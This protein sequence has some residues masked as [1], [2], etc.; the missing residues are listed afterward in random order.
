MTQRHDSAK[1]SEISAK[2]RSVLGAGTAIATWLVLGWSGPVAAAEPIVIGEGPTKDLTRTGTPTAAPAPADTATP[3]VNVDART[4]AKG[5]ANILLVHDRDF[6]GQDVNAGFAY[7]RANL[8]RLRR[9]GTGGM[10]IKPRDDR[11]FRAGRYVFLSGDGIAPAMIAAVPPVPVAR[12]AQARIAVAVQPMVDDQGRVRLASGAYAV[13]APP[14]VGVAAT[15]PPTAAPAAPV[16]ASVPPV[17]TAAAPTETQ[18]QPE[19]QPK[20][21]ILAEASAV[22]V[23][24][25]RPA[26]P[27]VAVALPPHRTAAG[28]W[29]LERQPTDQP[30]TSTVVAPVPVPK[31][32]SKPGPASA[33]PVAPSIDLAAVVPLPAPAPPVIAAS[34]GV[35][36]ATSAA[37]AQ[38]RYV[39]QREAVKGPAHIA[40]L[41]HGSATGAPNWRW[42]VN[43]QTG[44]HYTETNAHY[45]ARA[46][47]HVLA[48]SAGEFEALKRQAVNHA[49]DLA[50]EDRR[51]ISRVLEADFSPALPQADERL[52]VALA[53]DATQWRATELFARG[54]HGDQGRTVRLVRRHA[55]ILP[56]AKQ[57]IYARF[58]IDARRKI[59]AGSAA[60]LARAIDYPDAL[61]NAYGGFG[62]ALGFAVAPGDYQVALQSI[63]TDLIDVPLL[64][65]LAPGEAAR[66]VI[67]NKGAIGPH[68]I[69]AGWLAHKAPRAGPLVHDATVLRLAVIDIFAEARAMDDRQAAANWVERALVALDVRFDRRR[70]ATLTAAGLIDSFENLG[71][72]DITPEAQAV[73]AV[74]AYFRGDGRVM[75]LAR[76]YRRAA[77]AGE[78]DVSAFLHS[79]RLRDNYAARKIAHLRLMDAERQLLQQ[80]A[81]D[82]ARQLAAL[83][84][85]VA[86][87]QADS[88][89]FVAVNE[90]DTPPWPVRR[91]AQVT[92]AVA[93]DPATPLVDRIEALERDTRLVLASTE[94]DRLVLR[95]R[96]QRVIA[97]LEWLFQSFEQLE[98]AEQR[99]F[100]PRLRALHGALTAALSAAP[101]A[102]STEQQPA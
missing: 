29:V 95:D 5:P 10:L 97:A 51:R 70:M 101:A 76:Q 20:T 69:T 53:T 46:G 36:G 58:A 14:P 59:E 87:Q 86:Q 93:R 66:R 67:S 37:D 1:P 45:A 73:L 38:E 102:G 89:R 84:P 80:F 65:T 82:D 75:S 25:A 41:L 9:V 62:A 21:V 92:Q 57:R 83:P 11:S 34:T 90:L 54:L 17:V 32:A 98:P 8:D 50:S 79:R 78:V 44:D 43:L 18:I 39:S 60:K 64:L 7:Q 74:E 31:S 23:P 24:V 47:V 94:S 55:L 35:E 56:D 72:F 42:L 26:I 88:A 49:R 85:S 100:A 99:A 91:P 4:A 3:V 71:R 77:P 40:R 68:Q 33:Q 30:S 28:A 22:P 6:I 27:M 19:T 16:A 15:V 63:E 96:K 61:V 81:A 52:A 2:G 13:M 12:P 48:R